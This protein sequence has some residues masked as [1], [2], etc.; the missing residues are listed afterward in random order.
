[1][2]ERNTFERELGALRELPLSSPFSLLQRLR[3][4]KCIG[5][6]TASEVVVEGQVTDPTAL[7]GTTPVKLVVRYYPGRSTTSA[8]VFGG[9]HGNEDEGVSM[10][11]ALR[12]KLDLAYVPVPG[13]G[14]TPQ[15]A[16]HHTFL[17]ENL[18]ADRD[19]LEPGTKDSRWVDGIEP[20]RNFPLPGEG[21]AAVAARRKRLGFDLVDPDTRRFPDKAPREPKTFPDRVAA[22]KAEDEEAKK[23]KRKPE[24]LLVDRTSTTILPE[25]RLLMKL[26]ACIKPARALSAHSHGTGTKRG[27]SPGVFIDP[28]GGVD[29]DLDA[30]LTAEGREDDAL[31]N[32]LLRSAEAAIAKSKLRKKEQG[33]ALAGNKPGDKSYFGETVH[34]SF[35]APKARGT[36]FGMWAPSPI[37]GQGVDDR[38]GI[39]TIT[40]ELPKWF[41]ELGRK[42]ATPK[43]NELAEIWADVVMK[44][45][46]DVR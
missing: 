27:D 11:A 24:N 35:G 25:N 2:Q 15:L 37:V 21:F 42:T 20:N 29:S 22:Q 9:V 30:P 18:R 46:L 26:V 19:G 3:W 17:V 32:R 7:V 40:L 4:L 23:K 5:V 38:P 14:T 10:L 6:T 28:R 8:L 44:D 13:S 36:S 33:Q 45:F 1:M 34:Y 43:V 12:R 39:Q 16:E 31:A 41:E